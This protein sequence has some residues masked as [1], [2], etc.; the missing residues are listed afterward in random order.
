MFVL[1]LQNMFLLTN[2]NNICIENSDQFSFIHNLFFE[3]LFLN[4]SLLEL[5]TD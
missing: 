4:I 3:L 5:S 2:M 1:F